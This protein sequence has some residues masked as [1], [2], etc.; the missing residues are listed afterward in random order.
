M[1]IDM[2]KWSKIV[3]IALVYIQETLDELILLQMNESNIKNYFTQ[4][5]FNISRENETDE[6]K[7]LLEKINL[8][9][10]NYRRVF[11][12]A[13]DFFIAP[14]HYQIKILNNIINNPSTDAKEKLIKSFNVQSR[15]ELFIKKL[16]HDEYEIIT[17][18]LNLKNKQLQ[19]FKEEKLKLEQNIRKIDDVKF[20]NL[21]SELFKIK[22]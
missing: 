17:E 16:F 18:Y 5:Y 3:S 21:R 11:V 15:T 10:E 13:L 1:P 14:L 22:S 19:V 7:A 9:R 2:D 20:D 12:S 8:F 4:M 6:T